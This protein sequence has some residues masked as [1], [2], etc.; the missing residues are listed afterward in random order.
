MTAL[1]MAEVQRARE[2]PPPDGETAVVVPMRPTGFTPIDAQGYPQ[3]SPQ[4]APNRSDPAGQLAGLWAELERQG[5][6]VNRIRLDSHPDLIAAK[7]DHEAR[8]IRALRERP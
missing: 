7:V 5:A 8:R 3:T 4:V 6:V 1:T 2:S